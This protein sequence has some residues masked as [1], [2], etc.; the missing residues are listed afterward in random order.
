[1]KINNNTSEFW[2]LMNVQNDNKLSC[3]SIYIHKNKIISDWITGKNKKLLNIGAG[4]GYLESKILLQ[5]NYIKLYG[6]DISKLTI[7]NINKKIKGN[8]KVANIKNIPFSNNLFDFVLVID[9]L[10][11]LTYQ[12]LSI[13]IREINRVIKDNGKLI[14][15]VP[16]NENLIDKKLNR[17]MMS[18]T[19]EKLSNLLT[20]N[21]F[22]ISKYKYLYAFKNFYS[23]KSII[24]KYLHIKKPNL[25]IIEAT[26]I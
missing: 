25:L 6:I 18:F 13:S 21:S 20:K 14:I 2:D 7:K 10:E 8:F 3:S 12:E 1:M 11:H 23:I 26:K 24:V 4:N 5:N 22:K 9:I 19:L 15:S 16:L 17:H